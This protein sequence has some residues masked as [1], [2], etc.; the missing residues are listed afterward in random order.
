MIE[1]PRKRP[2]M[3]LITNEIKRLRVTIASKNE[4]FSENENSWSDEESLDFTSKPQNPNYADKMS[5]S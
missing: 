5:V 1:N 3:K 2:A 4:A